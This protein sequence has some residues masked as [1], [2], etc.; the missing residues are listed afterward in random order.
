MAASKSASP[1][2]KKNINL[3]SPKR[4]MLR[5]KKEK[6][7]I[8]KNINDQESTRKKYNKKGSKV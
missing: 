6:T 2:K 3:E 8:R 1:Q 4:K 7:G 5:K